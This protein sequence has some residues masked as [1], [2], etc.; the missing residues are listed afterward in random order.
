M[1][2]FLVLLFL[3]LANIT[4][5]GEPKDATPTRSQNTTS[6][7][8][9]RS[10]ISNH[11]PKMARVYRPLPQDVIRTQRAP[12]SGIPQIWLYQRGGAVP[13]T[14]NPSLWRQSQLVNI[15]GL[16]QVTDRIHQ[17]RNCDISNMTIIEGE[18]GIIV[19]DPLV[20]AQ[21][22]PAAFAPV[23]PAS[24]AAKRDGRDLLALAH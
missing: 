12:R 3:T 18:K 15:S 16:F 2:Y 10:P 22:A 24:T 7:R 1:R 21:V 9:F 19:V 13:D 23:F 5:A 17:V 6:A 14:V 4:K 11:S 8:R 20:S